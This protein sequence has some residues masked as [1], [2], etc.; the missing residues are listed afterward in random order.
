MPRA[1]TPAL[2]PRAEPTT[3]KLLGGNDTPPR[4]PASRDERGGRVTRVP[5][6]DHAPKLI[7]RDD[8]GICRRSPGRI[9]RVLTPSPRLRSQGA[10]ATLIC[11]ER[12]APRV[13]LRPAGAATGGKSGRRVGTRKNA[14][15]HVVTR[16]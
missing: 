5:L 1:E 4:A 8:R 3:T 13:A 2:T 7:T 6:P 11:P 16:K 15:W 9:E 10:V 14:R 12:R